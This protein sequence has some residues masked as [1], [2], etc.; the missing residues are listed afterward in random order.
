MRGTVEAGSR[1]SELK[2]QGSTQCEVLG[3]SRSEL[4]HIALLAKRRP[5]E[6]VHQGRLSRRWPWYL[7]L[8][9]ATFDQSHPRRLLAGASSSPACGG[10]HVL[11]SA[12]TR[13]LLF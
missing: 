9:A 8:C 7:D 11:L 3:Y 13:H 5:T 1:A 4:A 10:K 2:T 6:V 12:P